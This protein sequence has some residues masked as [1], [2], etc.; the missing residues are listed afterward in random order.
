M[1]GG[2][3]GLGDG[4]REVWGLGVGGS[5]SS[6]LLEGVLVESSASRFLSIHEVRELTHAGLR[7]STGILSESL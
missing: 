3:G 7:E 4:G 1:R 2:N 5:P 6:R